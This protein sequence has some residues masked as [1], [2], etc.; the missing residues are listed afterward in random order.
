MPSYK[1][2][3]LSGLLLLPMCQSAYAQ[4][5]SVIDASRRI[6]WSRAGV[7]DGIPNRSTICATLNPGSTAAQINS[8]I[9]A[10]PAGQVVKLN[11]GTYN[12]SSGI[13]FNAKS[14]VTLRGAGADQTFLVFTA[15]VTCG[16]MGGDVCFR[17]AQLNNTDSPGNT[18]NWTGGYAPGT[19]SITLSSTANLRAGSLLMLDQLDD[20]SDGGEIF[21]CQAAG[22]CSTDGPG[23]AGRNGRA[24]QQI[25]KVTG[26]SGNT[27]NITPGI[28]MPNWR[29]SQSPGAWWSSGLP[30]VGSGMEDLSVNHAGSPSV[31][32]GIYFFNAY[33][34]WIRN[35]RSLNSNRNHVWL[36]QSAHVTIRDSYFYGTLNAASQ[37]YGVEAYM[38]SD[39]LVENNIFQHITAAVMVGGS[40]TGS[41]FAYNFAI[42]DYYAVSP[43]WMQASYYMHAAGNSFLL[44]EG[45]EGPGTNSD[46]VH[47]TADFVTLF[48]NVL[49]GWE[50]GK[51]QQT[52]AV[53]IYAYNRYY[54]VL[55]N[56]LGRSGYHNRYE[57]APPSGTNGHTSIYTIGWSGNG[58]TTA[59]SIPNDTRVKNTLFRWGN[60]DVVTNAVQWTAAEVPSGLTRFSNPVPSSQALPSSLYLSS[61]PPWW[62]GMPWPPIGPEITGGDNANGHAYQTP[63]RI[64][65][66]SSSRT[67]GILNFNAA[68]CYV[69]AQAPRP[70]FNVRVLR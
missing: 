13:D 31:R 56:V 38:T 3:L 9:A 25:V 60:Y 42:D 35:V 6:D 30:I 14:N 26:V 15:G 44:W 51:T 39:S 55:G 7:T 59:G 36:Y 23:G 69:D 70:P 33:D 66:D 22:V 47:G 17:G 16:G 63:A 53:H 24:Q 58:G 5:P 45:N 67:G 32:S 27:V 12:L 49:A 4:T 19:S 61:R 8:A 1:G 40:T 10:C 11:A 28:Y 50:P 34:C 37:S 21:V 48:R 2:F 29:S 46:T 64:C 62:G 54:N 65:Y 57:S 18:A 52:V 41:V 20:S 68:R 43:S